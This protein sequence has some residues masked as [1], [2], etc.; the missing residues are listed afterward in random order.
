[1]DE[2]EK[3]AKIES[4][5]ARLETDISHLAKSVAVL[6]NVLLTGDNALVRQFAAMRN[7][8]Q[9][10]NR[11]MWIIVSGLVPIALKLFVK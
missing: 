11:L 8:L 1:M 6:E 9:S 5:I 2:Q 3:F 4:D 7:S 10:I